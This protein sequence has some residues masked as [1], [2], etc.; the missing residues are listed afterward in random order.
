[1]SRHAKP[2]KGRED[3]PDRKKLWLLLINILISGWNHF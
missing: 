1:M 2:R 3:G